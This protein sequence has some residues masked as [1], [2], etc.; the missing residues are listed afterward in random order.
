MLRCAAKAFGGELKVICILAFSLVF[1]AIILNETVLGKTQ[2]LKQCP[3]STEA[4]GIALVPPCSLELQ[5]DRH[6]C[7]HTD[8]VLQL[9][10]RMRAE[11]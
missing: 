7:I 10:L 4:V 11:G 8:Q 1:H 6:T 5:I 9:S 2:H 3:H